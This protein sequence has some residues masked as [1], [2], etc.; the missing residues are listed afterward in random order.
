MTMIN[1]KEKEMEKEKYVNFNNFCKEI[2]KG[3]LLIGNNAEWAKEIASKCIDLEAKDPKE[4]KTK[5]FFEILKIFSM[6]DTVLSTS[7]PKTELH[8]KLLAGEREV[9]KLV[10]SD[11]EA[12]MASYNLSK[13]GIV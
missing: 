8:A 5:I 12:L 11:I 13:E 7:V 2:D 3:E 4:V 10:R 1:R 6:Y 9:L